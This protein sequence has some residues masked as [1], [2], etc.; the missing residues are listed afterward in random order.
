MRVRAEA[1]R[2]AQERRGQITKLEER[3]LAKQDELEAK[4]TELLRREQGLAD[5]ETNIKELQVDLKEAKNRELGELERI[6]V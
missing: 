4:L 3:V 5:R 1:E 2:D 6:S